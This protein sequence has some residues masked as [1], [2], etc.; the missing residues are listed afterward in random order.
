MFPPPPHSENEFRNPANFA[1]DLWSLT[2]PVSG[3]AARMCTPQAAQQ[4][5]VPNVCINCSDPR[6]TNV[7]VS[8]HFVGPFVSGS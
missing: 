5:V 8:V 4:H 1:S 3:T 2:R 7:T 6:E